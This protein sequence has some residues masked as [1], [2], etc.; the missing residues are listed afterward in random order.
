MSDSLRPHRLQHRKPGF[1]VLHHLLEFPQTHVHWS[2]HDDSAGKESTCKPRFNPWVGKIPWRREG[3]PLQYS[4]LENSMDCIL[5]G[6]AKSRSN[7]F[8]HFHVY[9][10]G[11]AIQP[12]HPL[13]FLSPPALNLSQHQGL[14]RNTT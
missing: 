5:H 6:A 10:V 8:F 3:Y 9:W 13:L 4:G 12:S 1:S 11:D 2:F 7:F 14:K